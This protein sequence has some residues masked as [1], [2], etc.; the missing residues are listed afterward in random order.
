MS[1]QLIKLL[2]ALVLLKVYAALILL[3]VVIK[4]LSSPVDALDNSTVNYIN[5]NDDAASLPNLLANLCS[6]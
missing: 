3:P 2:S 5:R 6:I 1:K 4:V